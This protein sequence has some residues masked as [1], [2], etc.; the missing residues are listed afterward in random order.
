[1]ASIVDNSSID[2]LLSVVT[3]NATTDADQML[4]FALEAAKNAV[5]ESRIAALRP[6]FCTAENKTAGEALQQGH[7]GCG[8]RALGGVQCGAK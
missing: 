4:K 1:M 8:A 6:I 2:E 3:A 7:G 5:G